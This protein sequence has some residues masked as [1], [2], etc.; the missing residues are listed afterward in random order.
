MRF[1]ASSNSTVDP[2]NVFW[3]SQRDDTRH[4]CCS[5]SAATIGLWIGGDGCLVRSPDRVGHMAGVERLVTVV[6]LDERSPSGHSAWTHLYAVAD[7][8]RRFLLLDD[9][10]WSSSAEIAQRDLQEIEDTAR[11]VVGPDGPG[12]GETD[13]QMQTWYW[14]WME[15]KLRDASI[16][17]A[18]DKLSALPHEVEIG[19]RLRQRLHMST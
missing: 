1:I 12:P 13:E 5:D 14:E 6:E 19:E 15:H 11:M 18:A 9:R 16:S 2:S 3:L 17:A 10:G 7:D 4:D 8:G